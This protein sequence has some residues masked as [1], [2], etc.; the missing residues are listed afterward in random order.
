MS[1]NSRIIA[2]SG[3]SLPIF[4][5]VVWSFLISARILMSR[6]ESLSRRLRALP[7]GRERRNISMRC[8]A[9]S[10]TSMIP[11]KASARWCRGCL[12]LRSKMPGFGAGQLELAFEIGEGDID[13]AHGHSRID[14]A[15]QLHQYGEADAGAKHLRGVGVS[16]LMGDDICG[17]PSEWQTR[18]R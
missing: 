7:F 15:K 12:R 9:A 6:W 14:V 8:C 11:V 2:I 18:C 5:Q 1:V 10:R 3:Q 16:E 13:V 4:I 17:K